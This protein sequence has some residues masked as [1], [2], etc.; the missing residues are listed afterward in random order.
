MTRKSRR[1]SRDSGG[2]SNV[3]EFPKPQRSDD[4]LH[5]ILQELIDTG[6]KALVE[7][8]LVVWRGYFLGKI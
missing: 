3:I 4:E 8:H 1:K 5:E 6:H 7:M 2:P